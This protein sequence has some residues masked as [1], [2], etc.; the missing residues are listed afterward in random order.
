MVWIRD[1]FVLMDI[2]DNEFQNRKKYINLP[3][4]F[5][6]ELLQKKMPC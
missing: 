3:Y 5:T 2:I 4:N 6:I 1:R